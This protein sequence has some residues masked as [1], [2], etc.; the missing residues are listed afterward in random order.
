MSL[1][2]LYENLFLCVVY[3]PL[4][5]DNHTQASSQQYFV[6]KL[7]M[8]TKFMRRRKKNIILILIYK[9]K[10]IHFVPHYIGNKALLIFPVDNMCAWSKAIYLLWMSFV[11]FFVQNTFRHNEMTCWIVRAKYNQ[12]V[13]PVLCFLSFPFRI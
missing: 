8:I 10:L 7:T 13:R 1:W 11:L 3:F 12:N 6:L 9:D 5:P 4:L 2:E